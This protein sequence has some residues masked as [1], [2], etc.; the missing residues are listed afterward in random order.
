MCRRP[1]LLRKV[2]ERSSRLIQRRVPASASCRAQG[3]KQIPIPICQRCQWGP[4]ILG[5]PDQSLSAD[6]CRQCF[7]PRI[8]VVLPADMSNIARAALHL[9]TPDRLGCEAFP[10]RDGRLFLDDC[11]GRNSRLV[12]MRD[13]HPGSSDDVIARKHSAKSVG[14]LRCCWMHQRATSTS[15]IPHLQELGGETDSILNQ[16]LALDTQTQ[17]GHGAKKPWPGTKPS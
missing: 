15:L 13:K 17:V 3:D 16:L 12:V 6:G 10:P 9:F 14:S 4:H 8:T 1:H 2:C 11:P 5:M 7:I